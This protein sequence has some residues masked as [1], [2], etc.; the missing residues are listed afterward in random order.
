MTGPPVDHE[1]VVTEARLAEVEAEN[2]RLVRE[3]AAIAEQNAKNIAE[4]ERLR[5][6]H[7]SLYEPCPDCPGVGF[8]ERGADTG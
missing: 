5:Q 4:N 7:D 3:L 6:L 1:W 2:E 8:R